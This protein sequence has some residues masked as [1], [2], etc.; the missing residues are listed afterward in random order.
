MLR[1][2][3]TNVR[4]LTEYKRRAGFYDWIGKMGVQVVCVAE[5]KHPLQTTKGWHCV[6]HP[7]VKNGGVAV[8]V[9]KAPSISIESQGAA[10]NAAFVDIVHNNR[11]TRVISVYCPCRTEGPIT[12]L[13]DMVQAIPDTVVVGD[14]NACKHDTCSI[15]RMV[16]GFGYEH[17]PNK[18]SATFVSPTSR[19]PSELDQALVRD[20][21][22]TVLDNPRWPLSDHFGI[23]LACGGKEPRPVFRANM[24]LL[25]D[26]GC[27]AYIEDLASDMAHAV[28]AAHSQEERCARWDQFKEDVK[29]FLLHTGARKARELREKDAELLHQIRELEKG[30]GACPETRA[31][32][33]EVGRKYQERLKEKL[34]T[35][36]RG[37]ERTMLEGGHNLFTL[38]AEEKSKGFALEGKTEDEMLAEAVPFYKDLFSKHVTTPSAL[39]KIGSFIKHDEGPFSA[40]AKPFD[41]EECLENSQEM[42][43]GK[44][45]GPDGPPNRVLKQG[46]LASGECVRAD[47]QRGTF[48]HATVMEARTSAAHPQEGQ[49]VNH[50]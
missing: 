18:V 40:L 27:L 45:P 7:Q 14:W 22:W 29:E 10:K 47:L 30:R 32:W 39:S 21:S 48:V 6:C 33:D 37:W 16:L 26:K 5:I 36:K 42:H 49:A 28:H 13:R 17:L 3:F 43:V 24:S 4:G 46:L 44:S 41:E 11:F 50:W 31:L 8:L 12:E 9:K 35:R 20:K 23:L 2:L 25:K 34:V 1:I 38:E 15:K 19:R